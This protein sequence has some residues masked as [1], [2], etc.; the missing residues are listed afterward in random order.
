MAGIVVVAVTVRVIICA[1]E[2]WLIVAIEKIVVSQ[3]S[4]FMFLLHK[5]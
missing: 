5:L 4:I 1:C 3:K 2:G